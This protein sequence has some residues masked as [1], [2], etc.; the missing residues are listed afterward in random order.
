M[1]N[2]VDRLRVFDA[3]NTI[4]ALNHYRSFSVYRC[5][6]YTLDASDRQSPI[7][8][9]VKGYMSGIVLAIIDISQSV[10]AHHKASVFSQPKPFYV[11]YPIR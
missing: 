2:F 5:T 8:L 7:L 4:I 1:Y 11:L 6:F 10:R 3:Q 9:D